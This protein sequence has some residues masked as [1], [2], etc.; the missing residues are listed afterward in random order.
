VTWLRNKFYDWG[1][2]NSME[3]QIPTICVG[4]LSVGGTG[5]TPMIEYLIRLFDDDFKIGTLSRG[6]KRSTEGFLIADETATALSIGDEP[7]QFYNKF[8]NVI[9]SV[10]ADR[11]NGISRLLEL[12]D[13]P[14]LILLDDAFQH[15][16]VKAKVNI[17][18]TPFDDLYV[19]DMLLPT[20]N[21]REPKS[22]SLR[23]DVI[24]VTKCPELISEIDKKEITKLLNPQPYQNVFFSWIEYSNAIMNSFGR[25]ELNTFVDKKVT[26]VTGIANSKPL[27]D[28]L[29]SVGLNFEHLNFNDHH[30]FTPNEIKNLKKKEWILTTEKDFM[31]LSPYFKG[32]EHVYYLPIELKMDKPREFKELVIN[33]IT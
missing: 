20:G 6:Y 25:K 23:A 7:F 33:S 1:I 10:D 8:N 27:I 19:N 3:Y 15:R 24:V 21:L 22:G 11:R 14:E 9:V 30:E 31:R 28:Y 5:K 2:F 16:K 29:E 17:L 18:L 4:N 13:P 12:K 26:L 32:S